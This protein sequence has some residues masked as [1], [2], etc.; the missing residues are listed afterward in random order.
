M[1]KSPDQIE[2]D[3]AEYLVLGGR[4]VPES[5]AGPA[6]AAKRAR[7]PAPEHPGPRA[8]RGP[9]RTPAR[10]STTKET[11]LEVPSTTGWTSHGFAVV[12]RPAKVRTTYLDGVGTR[13]VTLAKRSEDA[14]LVLTKSGHHL[15][16]LEESTGSEPWVVAE[17]PSGTVAIG[18]NGVRVRNHLLSGATWQEAI[19]HGARVWWAP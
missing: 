6:P 16:V 19:A 10:P 2:I 1:S 8:A 11:K 17:I 18:E 14:W 13:M 4:V 12:L 15:G 7:R 3:I 9:R 5:S